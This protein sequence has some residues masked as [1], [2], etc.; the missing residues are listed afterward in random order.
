[1]VSDKPNAFNKIFNLFLCKIADED[2]KSDDNEMDFQ[3]RF[4]DTGE[5]LLAR[6][7]RLYT[8]GLS[9]YLRVQT[10]SEYH[11]PLNEFAFIDVFD[12]ATFDHN[13]MVLREVSSFFRIIE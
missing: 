12:K 11:S 5:A 4:G 8:R 13:V 1:V 7:S 3:W 2:E 6:L 10:E 9:E